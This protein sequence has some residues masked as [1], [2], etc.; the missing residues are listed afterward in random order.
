ME[1]S[2]FSSERSARKDDGHAEIRESIILF[3]EISDPQIHLHT[4]AEDLNQLS[5]PA[6]GWER[7][8]Q[9]EYSYKTESRRY[10]REEEPG[11]T[12]I[13]EQLSRKQ[14]QQ[15]YTGNHRKHPGEDHAYHSKGEGIESKRRAYYN[16]YISEY[17]A[18]KG[19]GLDFKI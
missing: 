6:S 14:D 11:F 9:A 12:E 3:R 8:Q 19:D 13:L 17:Y 2:Y 16:R 5:I 10:N 1:R 15:K 4:D 7:S 18:P